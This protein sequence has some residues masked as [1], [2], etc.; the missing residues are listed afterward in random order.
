M[1][2]DTPPDTPPPPKRVARS[3]LAAFKTTNGPLSSAVLTRAVRK[4]RSRRGFHRPK[5]P[6]R[7]AI[8]VGAT[9]RVRAA[10]NSRAT[11]LTAPGGIRSGLRIRFAQAAR[12]NQG[13]PALHRALLSRSIAAVFQIAAPDE[14]EGSPRTI[15]G[16]REI[17]RYRDEVIS[18]HHSVSG[19]GGVCV[20]EPATR[21]RQV[22]REIPEHFQN[23]AGR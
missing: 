16:F 4:N 18:S 3:G 6:L 17:T 9:Y 19:V 5:R 2:I 12:S 14:W 8:S 11:R 13:T 10:V 22:A 21:A 1:S 7:W 15:N 23:S 20:L